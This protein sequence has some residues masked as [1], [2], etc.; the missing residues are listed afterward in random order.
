MNLTP[1]RWSQMLVS[2]SKNQHLLRES[3]EEQ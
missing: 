2:Y 3:R 1:K